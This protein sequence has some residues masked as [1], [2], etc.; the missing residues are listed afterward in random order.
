MHAVNS[1]GWF[2]EL[3]ADHQSPC[4]SI[5]FPA[6][7]AAP[8]ANQNQ[9]R[10]RDLLDKAQQQLKEK[11]PNRFG[12]AVLQRLHTIPR[13]Q[14]GEGPH[15]GIAIFASPDY[16]Q[17]IDLQRS[18]DD[19]VVVSD[20]FHVKPLIRTMQHGDRYE[21]L[22]YS[23][24]RIRILD[25]TELGV[26]ELPLRS[27]PANIFEAHTVPVAGAKMDHHASIKRQPH[28]KPEQFMRLVDRTVWEDHSRTSHLPLIVCAGEKHLA[29][30]LRCTKN[31]YVTEQGIALNPDHLDDRRLH[32]EAWKII[33]PRYRDELARLNNQFRFAKAHH[34]GSDELFQVAEAA[35]VGRVGT[36]IVDANV[37]IPG[38]LD[39]R[40][41]MIEQATKL[42]PRAEDL[43]DN[44]AEMVLKMD[45]EVYVLPH[46]QMP[47]DA[48]I[49][50][51]YRY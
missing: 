37:H 48:G 20:S 36:L 2:A 51:M 6:Q 27:V 22:C 9:V 15:D 42:D 40:S 41:G 44:L 29:E 17:V 49:A 43:L 46:E 39:R 7:R 25:G 35:A 16:L 30:F 47:T 38:V 32:V 50:A 12:K 31:P 24:K 11:F 10:F 28:M 19:L 18:V 4:V 14:L 21:I 8:P 3:L 13:E 33:E 5:Y 45:G 23:P 1:T 26:S 34:K